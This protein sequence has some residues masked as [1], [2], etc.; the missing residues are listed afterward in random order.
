MPDG[1]TITETTVINPTIATT[2]SAMIKEMGIETISTIEIGTILTMEI[3]TIST[4]EITKR[5]TTTITAIIIEDTATTEMGILEEIT[6]VTMEDSTIRT[7]VSEIMVK[8]ITTSS[9]LVAEASRMDMREIQGQGTAQLG[10]RFAITAGSAIILVRYASDD[11]NQQHSKEIKEQQP[12]Q[13]TAIQ[14]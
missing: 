2:T 5:I 3:E 9:A 14:I 11:R 8:Q 10:G 1:I 12:I 6:E 13:I 4:M 7:R